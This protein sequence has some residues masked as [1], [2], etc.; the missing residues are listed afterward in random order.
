LTHRFPPEHFRGTEVY[1]FELA[2]EMQTLGDEVLVVALRELKE[3][4]PLSTVRDEYRGVNVERICKKIKPD[5]F[6]DYFFDPQMDRIFEDITGD[7]QP[8]IIHATYFLGGLSLGM[9][10]ASAQEKKLVMT[11]TDFSS[12]CPRGQMLD[13]NLTICYGPREGVKCLYCLF[14][15]SWLFENMRLDKWAR[16]YMPIWLGNW[17]ASPELDLIKKRDKAI[18]KIFKEARAVIFAHPLT[19]L[20]FNRSGLKVHHPK[21]LDFGVDDTP[22]QAHE[23]SPSARL[24]IG[25][26]GQILPHKGLHIL[27]DALAGI[28]DQDSFELKIYGSLADPAEKSYFDSLGLERIKHQQWLGT[29]DLGQM[30]E[31]LKGIDLLVVPSLWQE[32]CPLVPKYA[33]LTGTRLLLSDQPGI[34]T[35]TESKGITLFKSGDAVSLRGAIEGLLKSKDWM[36]KIEPEPGLVVRMKEHA[37]MV[38]KIYLEEN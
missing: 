6:E 21:L 34:L 2:R 14:D 8:D 5:N 23:K 18:R 11:I 19:L 4:A 10:L 22:F 17:R 25:F 32:N 16:E 12:L 7:F 28:S 36:R 29:F 35:N 9:S 37:E 26:I 3:P 27:A 20:T 31:V 13:R 33:L 15:K 30:N 38:K 1:T 24:R